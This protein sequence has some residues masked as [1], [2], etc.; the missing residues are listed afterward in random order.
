MRLETLMVE[1]EEEEQTYRV[2][3]NIGDVGV[4]R[5]WYKK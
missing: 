3:A 1:E 4:A 5:S 2:T